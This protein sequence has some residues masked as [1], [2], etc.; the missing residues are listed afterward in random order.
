MQGNMENTGIIHSVMCHVIPS[1]LASMPGISYSSAHFN[2]RPISGKTADGTYVFSQNTQRQPKH[3]IPLPANVATSN[4]PQRCTQHNR[5]SNTH[6]EPDQNQADKKT[7]QGTQHTT[8]QTKQNVY[9][10]KSG[11]VSAS[12]K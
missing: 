2:Y 4:A 7:D 6:T 11:R 9:R 3:I 10:D 8:K 12:K 1:T 5:R